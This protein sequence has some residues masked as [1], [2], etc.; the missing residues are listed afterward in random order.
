M[1]KALM[2]PAGFRITDWPRIKGDSRWIVH[3]DLPP[4]RGTTGPF[5]TH[6]EAVETARRIATFEGVL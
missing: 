4:R 1:S 3:Y 2:L 6:G 5:E